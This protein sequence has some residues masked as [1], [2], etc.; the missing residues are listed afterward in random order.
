[1]TTFTHA[2]RIKRFRVT[3]QLPWALVAQRMEMSKSAMHQVAAGKR[4]LGVLALARLEKLELQAGIT[5]PKE[6]TSIGAR[7]DRLRRALYINWGEL[8]DH[9][10][11]SRFMMYQIK[12]GGRSLSLK[13]LKRIQETE[14]ALGITP[15]EHITSSIDSLPESSHIHLRVTIKDATQ[16][17]TSLLKSVGSHNTR[18]RIASEHYRQPTRRPKS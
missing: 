13:T 15:A 5:P 11:I 3:M 7:L 9:L 6:S 14:L 17:L 1:M 18:V 16:A 10:Q 4:S 2:E 8:A 12:N